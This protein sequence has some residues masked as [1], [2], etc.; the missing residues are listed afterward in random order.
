MASS[1]WTFSVPSPSNQ[2]QKTH[3]I[4]EGRGPMEKLWTYLTSPVRCAVSHLESTLD[5]FYCFCPCPLMQIRC[6]FF[7]FL[8]FT[9][10]ERHTN[11]DGEINRMT[12]NLTMKGVK[13]PWGPFSSTR[14]LERLLNCVFLTLW[15]R[16]THLKPWFLND[17][18]KQMWRVRV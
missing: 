10:I 12:V 9:K 11:Q 14:F 18:T 1:C 13:I 3:K 16:A 4:K 7:F 15:Q 6:H 17:G 2:G 8:F 5:H